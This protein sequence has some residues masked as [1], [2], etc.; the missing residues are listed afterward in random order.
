V[1]EYCAENKIHIIWNV[2]YCP[3]FNGIEEYWAMAKK[4]FK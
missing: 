4:K 1:K 2:P 3:W